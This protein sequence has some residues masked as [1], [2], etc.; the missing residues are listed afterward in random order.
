MKRLVFLNMSKLQTALLSPVL[1]MQGTQHSEIDCTSRALKWDCKK[2][3][4]GW[5]R[6]APPDLLL[7]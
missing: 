7:R 4:K 3:V 2:R 5:Q 1:R 6:T